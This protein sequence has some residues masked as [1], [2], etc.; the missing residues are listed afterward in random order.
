MNETVPD[1]DSGPADKV[2]EKLLPA[3]AT[4]LVPDELKSASA[5]LSWPA[6]GGAIEIA[7]SAAVIVTSVSCSVSNEPSWL[8]LSAVLTPVTELELTS[9]LPTLVLNNVP[10]ATCTSVPETST[11]SGLKVTPV[12]ALSPAKLQSVI[13]EPPAGETLL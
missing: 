8:V 10:S 13:S 2:S 9:K 1:A 6:D 7:P 12:N 5:R 11:W 3:A 4:Q